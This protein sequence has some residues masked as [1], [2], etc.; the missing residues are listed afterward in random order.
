MYQSYTT[1]SYTAKLFQKFKLPEKDFESFIKEEF[2][3]PWFHTGNKLE[4]GW[5]NE[6]IRLLVTNS[7]A[8]EIFKHK[9]QL[10]FNRKTYMKTMNDKELTLS[11]FTE[12]FSERAS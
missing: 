7:K 9:T 4:S 10:N 12:Y 6:L 5:R 2:Y 11:I 1:P 8:R 3:T